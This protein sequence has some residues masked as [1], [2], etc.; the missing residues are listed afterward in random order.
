MGCTRAQLLALLTALEK[1]LEDACRRGGCKAC[2]SVANL[3]LERIRENALDEALRE[4]GL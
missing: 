4:I 1:D 3:Y 2:L